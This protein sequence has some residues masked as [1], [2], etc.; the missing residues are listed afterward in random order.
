MT[1]IYLP[2]MREAMEKWEAFEQTVTDAARRRYGST[3][4]L[5]SEYTCLLTGLAGRGDIP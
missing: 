5:I 2:E 4:H 3:P 1:S